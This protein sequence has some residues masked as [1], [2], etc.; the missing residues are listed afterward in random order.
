MAAYS[1]KQFLCRQCCSALILHRAVVKRRHL[2]TSTSS[3]SMTAVFLGNRSHIKVSGEDA[4]GFLN[5]LVTNDI[6]LFN[7]DGRMSVLY[8]MMLNSKGRVLYDFLVYKLAGNLDMPM[9]LLECDS[10]AAS[11]I[12]KTIKP[13]RLRSRVEFSDVS[14]QFGSWSVIE[15]G[16]HEKLE[17]RRSKSFDNLV[18]VED[19]RL[20]ILGARLLL[21]RADMPSEYYRNISEAMDQDVYDVHRACNGVSEGLKDIEPGVALPLE[22]NITELCGGT[23]LYSSLETLLCTQNIFWAHLKICVIP[24][25]L[26]SGPY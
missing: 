14:Q 18:L 21:P 13:Y 17:R 8:S 6:N 25:S 24:Q 11:G 9:F 20:S 22:Y 15:E 2:C 26:Q 10:G 12:I 4:V 16:A 19:P 3:S 1:G 5:G 23:L 7:A